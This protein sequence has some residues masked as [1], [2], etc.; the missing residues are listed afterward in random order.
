MP[1]EGKVVTVADWNTYMGTSATAGIIPEFRRWYDVS[2][3]A[4]M[5]CRVEAPFITG[6][7]VYLQG[8]DQSG[9]DFVTHAEFGPGQTAAST[10]YLTRAAPP[11]APDRLNRLFRWKILSAGGD[12]EACFR[13]TGVLK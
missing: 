2:K 4:S 3:F 12:W 8:C 5:S 7:T 13:I 11:G 6:C 1:G 10:V 9:G